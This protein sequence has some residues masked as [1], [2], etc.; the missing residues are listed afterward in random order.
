MHVENRLMWDT[1]KMHMIANQVKQTLHELY[2]ACKEALEAGRLASPR[3]VCPAAWESGTAGQASCL[4][5]QLFL[6]SSLIH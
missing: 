2:L 4:H 6:P 3:P 5:G 1:K